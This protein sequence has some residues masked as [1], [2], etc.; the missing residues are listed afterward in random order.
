MVPQNCFISMISITFWISSQH[1]ILITDHLTH[2][3]VVV[4]S[5]AA[6][7]RVK[8]FHPTSRLELYL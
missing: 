5:Q 3:S 4:L 2:C 8:N 6:P 7:V 1:W